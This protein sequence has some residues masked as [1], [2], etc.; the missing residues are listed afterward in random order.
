[1]IRWIAL[2]ALVAA[3][4]PYATG[5]FP[6]RSSITALLGASERVVDAKLTP[7]NWPICNTM[8]AMGSEADWAQFNPD[9]ATGKGALVAED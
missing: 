9:F 8:S 5:D 4:G 7:E 2:P 6:W 3:V 1:M